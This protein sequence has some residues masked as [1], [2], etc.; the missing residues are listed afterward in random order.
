MSQFKQLCG[1]WN[2]ISQYKAARHIRGDGM[3]QHE[4]D[5]VVHGRNDK[6][7]EMKWE[8]RNCRGT[9]H[10]DPSYDIGKCSATIGPILYLGEN[11]REKNTPPAAAWL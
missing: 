9:C 2:G 11:I 7:N 4:H 10:E 3:G 5:I 8:V 1:T 6:I